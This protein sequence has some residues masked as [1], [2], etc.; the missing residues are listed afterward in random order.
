MDI[1][2]TR[3]VLQLMMCT[4]YEN[5]DNWT[6]AVSKYRN[7]IYMCQVQNS[8]GGSSS[9]FDCKRLRQEIT[10]AYMKVLRQHCLVARDGSTAKT[11]QPNNLSGQ[12]YSVFTTDICGI[13]ILY[14]APVIAQF[15]PNPYIRMPN[16][17]VDLYFRLDTMNRAEWS[18]H[19]RHDVLKWWAESF[20]VGIETVYIAYH[21]RN[22]VVHSI[23]SKQ[24]RDLYRECDSD[25][26]PNICGNFLHCLLG[27][28]QKLMAHIDSASTVYLLDYNAN[29][30]H[31]TYRV[32]EDR[33]VHS[34]IPDWYR[35]M[36]EENM[37]HLNAEVRFQ[38]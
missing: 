35:V 29:N 11:G 36:L 20:L 14:D 19:N 17:F 13:N 2:C 6:I 15:N 27:T 31:I 5:T 26:S 37:E 30:G 12:Y 34:F 7:T 33:N 28:I 24:I 3:Q 25:W 1:V 23:N 18:A 32:T 10:T 4:P 8:E 9:H 21:D 22:G 16:T 38:L